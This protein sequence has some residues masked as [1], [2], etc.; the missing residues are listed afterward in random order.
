MS[1]TSALSS[2]GLPTNV[3]TRIAK[4]I[5]CLVKSTIRSEVVVPIGPLAVNTT[6][7]LPPL[8]AL[9]FETGQLVYVRSVDAF[10]YFVDFGATVPPVADG[11]TVTT[12]SRGGNTRF[13]RLL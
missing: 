12:T 10:F 7:D 4:S 13:L 11:I 3:A 6:D 1:L 8:N 5:C 2:A 9:D